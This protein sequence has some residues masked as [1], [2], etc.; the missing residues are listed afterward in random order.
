MPMSAEV[1]KRSLF[2][3][4]QDNYR[5][6]ILDDGDLK[7]VTSFSFSLLIFYILLSSV[8]VLL[9]LLIVGFIA[10]TPAKTLIPGYGD[11]KS[12]QQF[13]DLAQKV[14]DLETKIE[15]ND[16]YT[17]GLKNML[18]SIKETSPDEQPTVP[19]PTQKINNAEIVEAMKQRELDHL[20]FATPISG[21]VSAEYDA[22][23]GHLG[24]D[25]LAPKGTPVKSI[26]EGYVVSAE[27]TI[28]SGN[29][30]MIQ[31]PKNLVSI[32]KHNS[33]NLVK[34]GQKVQTGQ[35]VAIVGNTGEK[36]TGPHLHIELWYDGQPVNPKNYITFDK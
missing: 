15:A 6:V 32:Y 3:R 30:V 24:T 28:E 29:T 8:I 22:S 4:L 34:A 33:A 10:F 31:H 2:E 35:A 20:I 11:I 21:P 16:T 14:E 17:L 36:S 1:K 23:I 7:E 5:L 25:V 13:M 9:S 19:N 27:T 18:K 26:M 12:N